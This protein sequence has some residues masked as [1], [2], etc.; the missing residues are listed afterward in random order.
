MQWG[1]IPD[2]LMPGGYIL[3]QPLKAARRESV[4]WGRHTQELHGRGGGERSGE[5]QK[6]AARHHTELLGAF[7][8]YV[9]L[10]YIAHHVAQGSLLESC[11]LDRRRPDKTMALHAR[12]RGQ[13]VV[14]FFWIYHL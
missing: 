4:L 1:K 8:Q 9:V 5:L 6:K 10:R 7:S 3:H 11:E 13:S 12:P 2:L 14:Y